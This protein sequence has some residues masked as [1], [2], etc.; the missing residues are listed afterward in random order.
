MA[1]AAGGC[2]WPEPPLDVLV[3]PIC[4]PDS[5]QPWA[6]LNLPLDCGASDG[7]LFVNKSVLPPEGTPVY[8]RFHPVA[9]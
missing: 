7:V 4:P 3:E 6:L 9:D 2:V 8:V 5:P 1:L